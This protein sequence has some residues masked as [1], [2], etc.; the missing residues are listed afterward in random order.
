MSDKIKEQ[1]WQQSLY[2]QYENQEALISFIHNTLES[3]AHRYFLKPQIEFNSD[4]ILVEEAEDNLG[5]ALKIS[6]PEI[7]DAIKALAKTIPRSENPTIVTRLRIEIEE[8]TANHGKMTIYSQVS[9]DH[10]KHLWDSSKNMSKK[11]LLTWDDLMKFRKNFPLVLEDV[12]TL[13]L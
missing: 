4:Y 6:H 12:C 8:L 2:S 3:F 7:K 10:P 1:Q 5:Q 11:S 13:L 9:W